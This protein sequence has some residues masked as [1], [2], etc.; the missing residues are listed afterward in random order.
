[1]TDQKRY[2]IAAERLK[3]CRREKGLTQEQIGTL[4]GVNKSTVGRWENGKI[5]DVSIATFQLLANYYDV[6]VAWLT[7]LDVQKK[8][9]PPVTD[10]WNESKQKLYDAIIQMSDERV[11]AFLQILNGKTP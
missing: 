3:Q 11:E 1:M 10:G 7:G 4:C 6:D 2:M 9:T 5:K 8:R